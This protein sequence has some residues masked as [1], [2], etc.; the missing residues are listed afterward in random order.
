MLANYFR[1]W[2]V[3]VERKRAR[4]NEWSFSVHAPGYKYFALKKVMVISA[5]GPCSKTISAPRD[6]WDFYMRS[7][8]IE[9]SLRQHQKLT[10]K[11]S[12]VQSSGQSR[13]ASVQWM[14][15]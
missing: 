6:L 5:T 11:L 4:D 15:R 13:D 9:M 1:L 10:K 3:K 2:I 8:K 14:C 12:E 7:M